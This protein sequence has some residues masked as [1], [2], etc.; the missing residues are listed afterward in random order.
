LARLA[1]APTTS[2]PTIIVSVYASS[3]FALPRLS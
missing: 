2:A 3:V 1:A